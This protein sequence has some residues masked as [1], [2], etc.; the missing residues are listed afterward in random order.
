MTTVITGATGL[1]GR[2]VIEQLLTQGVPPDQ[3]V[4]GGRSIARLTDLTARGVDV[5][6]IDYDAPETLRSAFSGA[7]QVLLISG[8]E[9]GRRLPQHR[10][11]IEAA[12]AAEVSL[13]AYTSILRAPTSAIPLA[14]EHK[15]TEEMLA[16]A[17]VPHVLLRN[18][19]YVENYTGQLAGALERGVILGSAGDGRI[20]AATRADFAAAAA[21]VLTSGNHVGAGYELAGDDSFTMTEFAAEV[22]RQS[23]TTVAYVDLPQ[24]EYAAALREVGLPETFADILAESDAQVRNGELFDDGGQLNRLIGRPTTTLTDAVAAGLQA[25]TPPRP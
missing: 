1:L 8:S 15:A 24:A 11:V 4:A 20:S 17:G 18:G 16:A 6:H 2:L 19:W 5:R 14:V 3:I 23:G 12:V 9:V 7:Q 13:I 21:A 10:A 22:S 25:L